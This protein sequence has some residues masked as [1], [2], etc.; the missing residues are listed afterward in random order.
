MD[1]VDAGKPR[2]ILRASADAPVPGA[3][4]R[5]LPATD[6]APFVEHFWCVRW[7][8]RSQPAQTVETLP[9]PSVHIVVDGA[10]GR[11]G[12]VRTGRFTRVLE[13][14]GDVFGIKFRPGG[15]R[16]FWPEPLSSLVDVVVPLST[17]FDG[18]GAG[19]LAR[20]T[21]TSDFGARIDAAEAFLRSRGP[22][23][24]ANIVLIERLAA[25][26]AGDRELT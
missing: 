24:D 5:L 19:L 9:H 16:A 18:E 15:F 11:I 26:V 4:R 6:L 21:A 22:Q 2:G 10:D 20:I 12:G 23:P 8:L 13:G 14:E 1:R 7:D 17:A 25:R 3:H